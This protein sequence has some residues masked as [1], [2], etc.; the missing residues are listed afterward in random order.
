MPISIVA[1]RNKHPAPVREVKANTH[2]GN[3]H[4]PVIT[5]IIL[6]SHMRKYAEQMTGLPERL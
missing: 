1:A 2:P 3:D 5:R 6:L 4:F